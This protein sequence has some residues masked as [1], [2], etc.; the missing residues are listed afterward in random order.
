M[1][2]VREGVAAFRNAYVD[3]NDVI[4]QLLNH[5]SHSAVIEQ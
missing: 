2:D 4:M 1:P 5:S 3:R